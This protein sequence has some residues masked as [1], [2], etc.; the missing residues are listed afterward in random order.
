MLEKCIC[1]F[2]NLIVTVTDI[3]IMKKTQYTFLNQKKGE[4][5]EKQQQDYLNEKR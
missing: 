4:D 3:V 5:R 2:Q 1:P